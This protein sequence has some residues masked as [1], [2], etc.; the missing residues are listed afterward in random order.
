V[1]SPALQV[2][3]DVG[4]STDKGYDI[5]REIR[6]LGKRI[7]QFHFKDAR[8]LLG[9][10]RIDFK[11]VREA[12]DDIEYSGWIHLEAAAP[13]GLMV[14]Y[15]ANLAFLRSLFPASPA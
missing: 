8:F 12:M 1:G 3:Y 2:Y 4:N 7:C 9:K 15:P 14:D 13:N 6:L 5:C 11:K 10:G